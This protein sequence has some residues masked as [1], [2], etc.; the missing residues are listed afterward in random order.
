MDANKLPVT[1]HRR[2][3]E[4]IICVE[5]VVVEP[6]FATFFSAEI[7]CKAEFS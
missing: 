6:R 2:L 3:T 5:Q 7:E 1:N 4:V